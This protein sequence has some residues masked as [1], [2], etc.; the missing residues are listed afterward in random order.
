MAEEYFCHVKRYGPIREQAARR[1]KELTSN[2]IIFQ[3][4]KREAY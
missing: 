1:G 2:P 3:K 4:E